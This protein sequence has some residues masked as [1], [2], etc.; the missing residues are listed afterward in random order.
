MPCLQPWSDRN[1]YSFRK[2]YRTFVQTRQKA[3]KRAQH[4]PIYSHSGPV[5][6]I[7]WARVRPIFCKRIHQNRIS[8]SKVIPFLVHFFAKSHTLSR[9]I[10]PHNFSHTHNTTTLSTTKRRA[11]INTIPIH[12]FPFVE[13]SSFTMDQTYSTFSPQNCQIPRTKIDYDAP[14]PTP[15]RLRLHNNP[16]CTL[17]Q[18]LYPSGPNFSTRKPTRHEQTTPFPPNTPLPTTF[19]SNTKTTPTSPDFRSHT[20]SRL[21]FARGT[22]CRRQK[23]RL[24]TATY[25]KTT[26]Y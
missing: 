17:Q 22:R 21:Y 10:L 7:A 24:A 19:T 26:K 1:I 16:S 20:T 4:F 2:A 18:L 25:S 6:G 11:H 15:D 14:A 12:L 5:F 13:P 8:R 23:L 9:P 3:P